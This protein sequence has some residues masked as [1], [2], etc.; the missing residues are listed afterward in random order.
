[1][2]KEPPPPPHAR[3]AFAE[4]LFKECGYDM[5][6]MSLPPSGV[7]GMACLE[8][9]FGTSSHFR[10][11]NILFGIT[12][13]YKDGWNLPGCKVKDKEWVYLPTQAV[14]DGPIVQDR[15]CIAP[16]LKDAFGIFRAFIENHPLLKSDR[17]KADLKAAAKDPGAFARV[18]AT[19]CLFGAGNATEYPKTVLKIIDQEN[20][21]RFDSGV[22]A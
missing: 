17:G 19:R 11:Y 8:S 13:P 6:A 3:H 20:L 7:I 1:M 22:I 15:F 21:R 18:M 12:A 5:M 9:A 2:A 10:D 14:K 16:T 4:R